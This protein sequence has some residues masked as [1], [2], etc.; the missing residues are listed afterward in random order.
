M[1]VWFEMVL[2]LMLIVVGFSL[3]GLFCGV[4]WTVDPGFFLVAL[5]YWLV[6]SLLCYLMPFAV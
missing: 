6:F 4:V 1:L 3:A 2:G 5:G